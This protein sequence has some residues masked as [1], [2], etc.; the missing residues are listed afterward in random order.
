M[1]DM[2]THEWCAAYPHSAADE[3]K[4]LETALRSAEEDKR[5]MSE[6]MTLLQGACRDCA[7]VANRVANDLQNV[8]N[9][10]KEKGL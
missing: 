7:N 8:R 3:I 9:L 5:L 2:K 1:D 6:Q 4:R 10:L